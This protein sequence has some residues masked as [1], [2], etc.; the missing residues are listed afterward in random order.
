MILE[1][2]PRLR[3]AD[4]IAPP[5]PLGKFP[6]KMIESIGEDII[7]A[8]CTQSVPKIEGND[9]ERIFAK[10]IGAS[11]KP[12]NLGLDDIQLGN[13]AWSAKTVKGKLNQKRVRLI[14]GRNSPTY[15]FGEGTINRDA[16]PKMIGA[17]VLSIWNA[18]V[19]SI[20]KRFSHMRTVVLIK[21]DDLLTLRVFES[22]TERY[23]SDR[24]EWFWNKRG[25]LE[26]HKGGK[27]F[28]TW[29]P[30]G[31]QFTIIADVPD[32]CTNF[33]LRKPPKLDE[34]VVLESIHYDKSWI[35]II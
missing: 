35:K 31:S 34:K 11:W 6:M 10:A 1:L 17:E 5:Y 30:H 20:R 16:D 33:K 2:I 9:W 26:G 7:Y 21:S 28:F 24:Y 25:N 3:A 22:E 23:D 19:D 4:K 18:R 12:S 8:I 13:C 29:Q 32:N 15:S 14:S 27:H